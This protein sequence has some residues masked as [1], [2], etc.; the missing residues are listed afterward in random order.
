M[1]YVELTKI[2][3]VFLTVINVGRVFQITSC[4]SMVF[5]TLSAVNHISEVKSDIWL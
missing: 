4:L 5:R 2:A 1:Q 3:Y